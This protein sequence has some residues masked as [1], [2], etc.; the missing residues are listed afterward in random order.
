MAAQL[1]SLWLVLAGM[2][3]ALLVA[4]VGLV[5]WAEISEA[6]RV[7]TTPLEEPTAP[8]GLTSETHQQL[9]GADV[10]ETLPPLAPLTPPAALKPSDTPRPQAPN[11]ASVVATE[12]ASDE[13]ATEP[14]P[15]PE[16]ERLPPGAAPIGRIP[17]PEGAQIM[18]SSRLKNPSR[19]MIDVRGLDLEPADM[20]YDRSRIERVR[21][22]R[23]DG[24][25]RLVLD[26]T[27]S[28]GRL[29]PRLEGRDLRII[30]LD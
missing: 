19:F 1:P 15:E 23:H 3:A 8:A 20:D 26:L 4:A 11:A 16:A 18:R 6:P 2:G 14:A 12:P 27:G 25:G 10:E 28:T 30:E 5:L 22:G 17:L 9:M 13:P 7:V 24:F 21:F 29:T